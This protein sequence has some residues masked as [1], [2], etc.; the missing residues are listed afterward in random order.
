MYSLRPNY[1][2]DQEL[3]GI[4]GW[5]AFLVFTVMANAAILALS[6]IGNTLLLFTNGTLSKMLEEDK[7]LTGI[8]L[9]ENF[10]NLLALIFAILCIV[11]FFLRKAS[12]RKWLL[13]FFLTNIAY[14]VI[15]NVLNLAFGY[16]MNPDAIRALAVSGLWTGY[17]LRSKRLK[18]TFDA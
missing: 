1:K 14:A 16:G 17:V 2:N 4:K 15:D 9:F 5:L 13:I 8:V 3:K 12:T 11:L 10:S 6:F 7:I 18:N